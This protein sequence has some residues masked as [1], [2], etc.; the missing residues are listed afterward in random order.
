MHYHVIFL[1]AAL[2]AP[3]ALASSIPANLQAFYDNHKT[4][5]CSKALAKGFTDGKGASGFGY[6]NDVAG[7]IYLY[8][9]GAGGKYA[10]MDIDCDG[11]NNKA[12]KC[13]ND[14]SGQGVTAFK[15]TVK[16]YGIK[17]LDANIHPYVV[18][19]N[20][21]ASPSFNPQ[22]SGMKP[23]SV[24][25]IVCDGKLL[26]GIWG[27][28]NGGTSTGE[29]SIALADL[30]FPNEGLNA[31]S[32]HDPHDVL[33]I[34]FTDSSAAPGKSGAKW[35]ASN[36]AEFEASIKSLGDKLVATL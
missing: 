9:N 15:D 6:C 16:N 20:E 29:A 23:L 35:T 1:L 21:E 36:T 19:G 2:L 25:A 32:G 12:G 33:Y 27:D 22:N 26:Y 13:K 17:D 3:H 30:C 7:T 34:G 10:D 24:M 28:T 4:G 18:F 11:A 14:P 5:K 31:D 8:G